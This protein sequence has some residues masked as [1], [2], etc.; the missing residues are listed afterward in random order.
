MRN[1]RWTGLL[2]AR[3]MER[4]R[5]QNPVAVAV[6]GL[7]RSG[8]G[9]WRGGGASSGGSGG[10]GEQGGRGSEEQR[11]AGERDFFRDGSM[12][13]STLLARLSNG[14]VW[15]NRSLVMEE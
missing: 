2:P 14:W 4:V 1:G 7:E 15:L 12:R 5:G 11:R 9:P 10:L 3:R 8:D 6:E 13:T